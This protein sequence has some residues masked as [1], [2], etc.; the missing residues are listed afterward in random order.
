[1]LTLWSA[2]HPGVWLSPGNAGFGTWALPYRQ[3]VDVTTR[4]SKKPP[5]ETLFDVW[6]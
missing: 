1:M 2:L 6:D 5:P 3:S 4:E